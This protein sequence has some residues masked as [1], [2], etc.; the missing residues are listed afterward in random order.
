MPDL[1]LGPAPMG[2]PH[3]HRRFR[4]LEYAVFLH[5]EA[6]MSQSDAAEALGLHRLAVTH[7]TDEAL[8][9]LYGA[10]PLAA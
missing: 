5:L 3:R 9:R 1:P 7:A 4:R 10:L 6:G 2:S 8:R